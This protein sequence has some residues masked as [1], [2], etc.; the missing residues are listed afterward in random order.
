[1][2]RQKTTS[3]KRAATAKRIIAAAE[4]SNGLL[5]AIAEAAGVHRSTVWTY[6]RDYPDVAE[7]VE[8]AREKLFDVAESKLIERIESGDVTA[9]IFFLKTRC[10]HRGYVERPAEDKA[11]PVEIRVSYADEIHEVVRRVEEAD[12]DLIARSVRR[13]QERAGLIPGPPKAPA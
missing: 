8:E 1:M 10:K 7:A 2:T 12:P 9:I 3:K 13:A 6:A 11:A 5:S 4:D